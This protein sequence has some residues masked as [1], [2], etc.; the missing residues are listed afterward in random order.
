M[1][2]NIFNNNDNY[3]ILLRDS[4]DNILTNNIANSNK[5][6]GIDVYSDSL[7]NILTGNTFSN[8]DNSGIVIKSEDTILNN[9][10]ACNNGYDGVMD[11]RCD[12]PTQIASGSEN[13]FGDVL[14][15]GGGWPEEETHYVSSCS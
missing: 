6:N 11:F 2:V 10:I 9:N 1:L 15:C 8:N 14:Q 13:V 3:G 7:R 4:S 12:A 5:G